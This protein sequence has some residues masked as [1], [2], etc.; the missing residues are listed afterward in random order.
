MIHPLQ[1]IWDKQNRIA[2]MI[3]MIH[4]CSPF[5]AVIKDKEIEIIHFLSESDKQKISQLREMD[6]YCFA[7]SEKYFGRRDDNVVGV[8]SL[9]IKPSLKK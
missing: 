1:E 7:I 2:E 4:T 5:T 9:K 3:A 8:E 6:V